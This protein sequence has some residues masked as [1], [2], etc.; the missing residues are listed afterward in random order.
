MGQLRQKEATSSWW[1]HFGPIEFGW[2]NGGVTLWSLSWL[3]QKG[4]ATHRLTLHRLTPLLGWPP[5]SSLGSPLGL[6][7][8]HIHDSIRLSLLGHARSKKDICCAGT[9]LVSSRLSIGVWVRCTFKLAHLSSEMN[10]THLV[11]FGSFCSAIG[12]DTL[13]TWLNE[14]ESWSIQACN[15]CPSWRNIAPM[16]VIALCV[17]HRETTPGAKKSDWFGQ[18]CQNSSIELA[19]HK[20]ASLAS[21]MDLPGEGINLSAMMTKSQ[22][23]GFIVSSIF[24]GNIPGWIYYDKTSH[25]LFYQQSACCPTHNSHQNIVGHF[26]A[27]NLQSEKAAHFSWKA[28]LHWKHVC[29]RISYILHFPKWAAFLWASALTHS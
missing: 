16:E 1:C 26:A 7:P 19:Q 9:P 3:F 6:R 27:I 28:W 12:V 22:L 2:C 15:G 10:Y 21:D 5:G 8:R 23:T 13:H 4:A 29:V 24:S 17:G 20:C 25:K 14:R 18:Q 11:F